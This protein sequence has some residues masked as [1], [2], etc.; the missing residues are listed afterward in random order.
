LNGE[1]AF[2]IIKAL[3]AEK[4]KI[5][6]PVV[7]TRMEAANEASKKLKKL[8]RIDQLIFEERGSQDLHVGWPVVQG[9]FMDGTLVRCPLLFFP[10]SLKV[11]NNQ[12]VLEP[13]EEQVLPLTNHLY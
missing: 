5:I 2:S 12:W 6:C 11:H 9:K 10:V 8:Q 7:D 13:R 3:I 4:Q 1:N